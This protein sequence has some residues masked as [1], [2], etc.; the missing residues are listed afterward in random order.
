[1]IKAKGGVVSTPLKIPA[2]E[3]QSYIPAIAIIAEE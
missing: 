2:R 1:M 3:R